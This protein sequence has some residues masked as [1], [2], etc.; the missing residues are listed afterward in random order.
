MLSL[1]KSPLPALAGLLAV[2]VIGVP[3][4][5]A[6]ATAGPQMPQAKPVK[7]SS[8][9]GPVP[10]AQTTASPA[11]TSVTFPGGKATS[12]LFWMGPKVDD[13]GYLIS[14]ENATNLSRN[15][16]S[17]RNT[18]DGGKALT[19]QRPSAAS[20]LS[21]SGDEV[22]VAW[23]AGTAADGAVWYSIGKANKGGT[24]SWSPAAAVPGALTSDGPTV[25]V[26]LYSNVF[27]V[28]WTVPKSGDIDYV[29]GSPAAKGPV[30][31]GPVSTLP[32]AVSGDTPTV[33][34]VST[35]LGIGRVYVFWRGPGSSGSISY[36]WTPDPVSSFPKWT[37]PVGL[38][39]GDATAAAPAAEAVGTS[40]GFPLLVVYKAPKGTSLRYVT[41]NQKGQVTGPRLVPSLMSQYGP[42]L[43]E[44]VLM[45]TSPHLSKASSAH[46][47]RVR[48]GP[49]PVFYLTMRRPCSGCGPL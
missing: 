19:E 45:A 46:A 47:V 25:F 34:E 43:S 38:P 10:R 31:W 4:L 6:A 48:M 3:V 18:V 36:S 24:L 16:W 1:K 15:K 26:P 5:A 11:V 40:N 14:Y 20:Y 30:H 29:I 33:A 9:K 32:H 17:S 41:L 49:R 35:G 28:T 21:S 12:L 2:S 22:I 8:L 27:L 23:K 44:G 37:I 13:H 42:A 39:S 7:W